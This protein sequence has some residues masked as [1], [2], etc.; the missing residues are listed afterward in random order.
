MSSRP[1]LAACGPAG[2]APAT[3]ASFQLEEVIVGGDAVDLLHRRALD[4][5]LHS[6]ETTAD[7]GELSSPSIS[8]S[9]R[10]VSLPAWSISMERRAYVLSARRTGGGL[11]DLGSLEREP[12]A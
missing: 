9:I 4:E 5:Q 10:S 11:R 1:R 8:S 3:T 7:V 2:H 6:S 12:I